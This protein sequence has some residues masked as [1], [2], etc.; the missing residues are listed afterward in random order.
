MTK[1]IK[2]FVVLTI[3]VTGCWALMPKSSVVSA[4]ETALINADEQASVYRANC[5][6]CHGADG[7]ANTPAG[8]ETDADDL[9]TSKV[10]NLSTARMTQIIKNGKGDM[11]AFGRKLSAAQ[12]AGVI[13]YVKTL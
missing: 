1:L 5:A 11:P 7:H 2:I 9:T 8:R 3:C 4:S 13:R 6:R 10:K 12:I